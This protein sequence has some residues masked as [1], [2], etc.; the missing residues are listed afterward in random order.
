MVTSSNLLD[1]QAKAVHQHFGANKSLSA[2]LTGFCGL[3]LFIAPVHA[4]QYKSESTF[5]AEAFAQVPAAKA[6]WITGSLKTQT[7]DILQHAPKQLRQR[8]WQQGQRSAWVMNEIGKEKPITVGIVV[9][10]GEIESLEV[11]AFRES[12]G[13]EVKYPFFTQQ[14]LAAGLNSQTQLTKNIDNITGATLSVR[15]VSKLARLALLYH[16]KINHTP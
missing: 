11:L 2:L 12:R 8:Y 14:F 16:Q 6:L 9:N 1:H 3:L 7:A 13:W 10:H 4:K 15:A 5:I